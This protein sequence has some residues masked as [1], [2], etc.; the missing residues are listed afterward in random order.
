[1]E[2]AYREMWRRWCSLGVPPSGGL[3]GSAGIS[4]TG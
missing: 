4:Q 1:V 3:P 2:V